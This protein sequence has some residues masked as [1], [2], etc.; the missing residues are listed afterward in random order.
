LR[1]IDLKRFRESD[2]ILYS[3]PLYSFQS[4][5]TALA[6]TNIFFEAHHIHH[7]NG[8][9]INNIPLLK[10][11]RIRTVVGG[12][13]LYVKDSNFRHEEVFLGLERVFKLGARRRLRLGFYGVLANS[14]ISQTD[15]N[16]K[17]SIDVIDTWKRDWSF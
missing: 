3:D 2:P 12:G 7:F 4:L 14:N 10:K 5:D 8:A 13:F 6:T 9:L 1:F 11:T 17:I 15:T 16:W